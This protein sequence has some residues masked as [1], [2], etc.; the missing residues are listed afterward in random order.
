MRIPKGSRALRLTYH[1]EGSGG[2]AIDDIVIGHGGAE[3]YTPL[4][5]STRIDAGTGT[6]FTVTGLTLTPT[7]TL[8]YRVYGHDGATYSLPSLPQPILYDPT[9]IATPTTKPEG[10]THWYD[11]SGRPITGN[12]PERPGI[13]INNR[14]EKRIKK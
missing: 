14:G 8:Y 6:S 2:L 11:L 3:T 12:R 9:G 1:R 5:G 10:P 7:E 13:Y 4:N